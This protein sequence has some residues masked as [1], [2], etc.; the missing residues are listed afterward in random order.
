MD[1][2]EVLN[3]LRELM[4]MTHSMGNAQQIL[5]QTKELFNALDTWLSNEGFP[6]AAW[7]VKKKHK[8][9]RKRK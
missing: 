4:S 3:Q 9:K 6:P 1:P 7:R 2:N 5:F 8:K